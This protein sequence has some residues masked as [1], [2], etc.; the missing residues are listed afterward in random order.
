[1]AALRVDE[2]EG[3]GEEGGEG[4]ERG[5]PVERHRLGHFKSGFVAAAV[6]VFALAPLAA[7]VV[8]GR[9]TA[10]GHGDQMSMERVSYG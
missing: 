4:D 5:E 2:E 3:E 10:F 6:Y 9:R 1:M 8:L 7:A